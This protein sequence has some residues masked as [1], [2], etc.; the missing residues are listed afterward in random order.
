MGP[1]E[2]MP[3]PDSAF[4][5]RKI[6]APAVRR[7]ARAAFELAAER[8]CKLTA[9]HKANVLNLTDGLFL[10][11][12]RAIAVEFPQVTLDTLTVRSAARRVGKEGGRTGRSRLS[13]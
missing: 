6:T 3:D 9:V 10:R 8:R 5:I 12:V 4:S 13:T 11:E 7:V 2:F 1:G